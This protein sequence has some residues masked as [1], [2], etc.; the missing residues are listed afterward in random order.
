[1]A[2]HTAELEKKL[3]EASALSQRIA[4]FQ[5]SALAHCATGDLD[6]LRAVRR[7]RLADLALGLVTMPAVDLLDRELEAAEAKAREFAREVEIAEAA[8]ARLQSQYDQ[9]AAEITPL[10]AELP[11]LK[12]QAATEVLRERLTPYREALHSLAQVH[13][14]VV[15]A[16]LAVDLLADPTAHPARLYVSNRIDQAGLGLPLPGL[17]GLDPAQFEVAPDAAKFR[18]EATKVLALLES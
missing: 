16:A 14:Q 9:L 13:A 1:M 8:A 7:E 15:G 17:E 2:A 6:A 12:Y 3:S 10:S 11:R 18:E 5:Q 4:N